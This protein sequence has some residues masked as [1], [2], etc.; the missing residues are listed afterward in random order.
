V[1]F[2]P[3]SV[4]SCK[5]ALRE[6]ANHFQSLLVEYATGKVLARDEHPWLTTLWHDENPSFCEDK[7]MIY[8]G[9]RIAPE[10][11]LSILDHGMEAWDTSPNPGQLCFASG[12]WGAQDYALNPTASIGGG[13]YGPALGVVFAVSRT[14][15]GARERGYRSNEYEV[16]RILPKHLRGIWIYDLHQDRFVPLQSLSG[17]VCSK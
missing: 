5:K 6:D 1:S 17:I 14:E 3:F 10:A 4:D 16:E 13:N 8:R 12:F 7:D 11:L 2:P 9:M 15:S